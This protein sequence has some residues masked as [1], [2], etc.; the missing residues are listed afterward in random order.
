MPHPQTI[1][2]TKERLLVHFISDY[3][4]AGNGF[5]LEW[6]V[7]G[8]GGLLSKV[9]TDLRH[10]YDDH[11]CYNNINTKLPQYLNKLLHYF[12]RIM[13]ISIPQIILKYTRMPLNVYGTLKLLWEPEL[14]FV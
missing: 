12:N 9:S 3:M 7:Q 1:T 11:M 10:N 4:V 2:S 8:C 5:R 6:R 14:S 13:A